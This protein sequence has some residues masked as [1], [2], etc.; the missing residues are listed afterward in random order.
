M[1]VLLTTLNAKYIHSNL[2]LRYLF[3]AALNKGCEDLALEEFTINQNDDFIFSELVS[4]GYGMI[5]FSCYTWNIERIL[6]IAENVKKAKP[7]I[8]ILLG[9]PE[10]SHRAFDLMHNHRFIDFLLTGESDVSFP[11]LLSV[12]GSS[13]ANGFW[14]VKGLYFR[15][16]S[17]IRFNEDGDPLEPSVI[18][19]P[20]GQNSFKADQIIYYEASRGCPFACS[21]C[22]SSIERSIRAFPLSRVMKELDIFIN[23]EVK[24]VKFV[25]RT[26]N[27][28][29]ARS[30]KLFQFLM[31][32]D[33]G[34]TNF[35]MEM[36]GDLIGKE[37]LDLLSD[38]RPGLFQFE[39]GVQS[40]NP[41]VLAAV[42]RAS[43]LQRLSDNVRKIR[44]YNNI[45]LHLDLI[46]GLPYEDYGSFKRSFNQI[47][48]LSPDCLQLG[49]LK[50][51]PGTPIIEQIK[52]HGYIFRRKAPYEVI[53]NKYI[54]AE[55]LVR[56]KRV[57]TVL[58]LYYNRG[59]FENSIKYAASISKTAF[60][61]YEEFAHFYCS[62]GFQKR[63]H[64]KENLY[65]ILHQYAWWKD[66][67]LPGIGKR[68]E[69]LI[70]KD[71]RELHNP[72][73]EKRM[74]KEDQL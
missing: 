52:E 39:I 27:W 55:S 74:L 46:A 51:L 5:C 14:N 56:L 11:H 40:T 12:I 24:Q 45:H 67:N 21:Y 59:G 68:L 1:K 25:D 50:M 72:E 29:E 28:D 64:G 23:R 47:Y 58:N 54:I 57:E 71:I 15:Q 8:L 20:Y 42:N 4:K 43:D 9:G 18:H 10:A 22:L 33:N 44:G 63:S 49:F 30:I 13:D 61:F 34:I 60:D 7:E 16:G 35:H 66:E 69:S 2:A 65:R 70:L 41:S 38:A 26:F 17:S 62:R 36:C 6:Y 32:R 3:E 19:F 73:A 48:E 53:S 31:D 37:L